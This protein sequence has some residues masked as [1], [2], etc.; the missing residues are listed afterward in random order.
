MDSSF[1]ALATFQN[2]KWLDYTQNLMDTQKI[3]YESNDLADVIVVIGA[4]RYQAHQLVLSA[5]SDFFKA[6]LD[7]TSV[8]HHQQT[9][10]IIIP[11]LNPLLVDPLF[12]F[13]YT[14]QSFVDSTVL[15]EFLEA[16]SFLQIKGFI[17]Y[18]C[19]VNGIR[20]QQDPNSKKAVPAVQQQAAEEEDVSTVEADK[21]VYVLPHNF[22]I[23]EDVVVDGDYTIK[24]YTIEDSDQIKNNDAQDSQDQIITE[25]PIEEY[26]EEEE[27]MLMVK[28]DS[29]TAKPS[30]TTRTSKSNA[31]DTA[32]ATV[33]G[34]QTKSYTEA[35][36][37]QA[38]EDLRLGA[39]VNDVTA[40][41]GIP[42]ST[43]Y[44]KLRHSKD[45]VYRTYRT[46]H[47][48]EAARAVTD[49][50][51]SL[52]EASEKFDVSKTVLWRTLKKTA[53]Y[54]PEER[55]H[56]MRTEATE[57]ILTGDTLISISRRFNIPL[58]TLHRDKVR[59]HNEGKLPDHCK[60]TRRD[61]STCYQK[62]LRAALQSCRSGMPQKA[63]SELHKVPKTTIWRHLQRLSRADATKAQSGADDVED[64][65]AS[66][67]PN[68]DEE[69]LDEDGE[70]LEETT[71]EAAESFEM[72]NSFEE[73]AEE[74]A[75]N[76][77]PLSYV[78]KY[79]FE[80]DV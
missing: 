25:A 74:A 23:A 27:E 78:E 10:V 8:V 64:A 43:I 71:E 6:V 29:N 72:L 63:A 50:G 19:L 70:E 18:D 40:K 54:K 38:I 32:L 41:Y 55:F 4:K 20:L 21:N 16:C 65:D 60:L 47:L 15:S 44:S 39:T 7:T 56:T 76:D 33:W 73:D 67:V 17:S 2:V 45:P 48:Q 24:E 30:A 12:E 58:A 46:S 49:T 57:A 3:F 77:D 34:R 62:R 28:S 69:R 75:A 22:E 37:N 66:V 52:K 79:E 59:L 14:G 35:T 51:L 53:N 68:D 36:L 80:A 11:D 1:E 5:C 26:L 31:D 13:M 61:S 42:R 9:P